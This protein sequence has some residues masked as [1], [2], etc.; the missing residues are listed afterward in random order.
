MT[1][2]NHIIIVHGN[3]IVKK[4]V[5]KVAIVQRKSDSKDTYKSVSSD[6]SRQLERNDTWRYK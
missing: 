4:H 6:D 2:V 5:K 1:K 3:Q